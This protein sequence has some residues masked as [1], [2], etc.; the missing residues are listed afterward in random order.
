MYEN[1]KK[2]EERE[3]SF[4]DDWELTQQDLQDI[5]Y[6][7]YVL[8]NYNNYTSDDYNE[9]LLDAFRLATI[10]NRE[11]GLKLFEMISENSLNFKDYE[12]LEQKFNEC[13]RTTTYKTNILGYYINKVKEIYGPD[14]KFRFNEILKK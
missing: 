2:P 3:Y 12:D 5:V 6:C 4:E 8:V 11:V 13:R 1:I 9:W 10:P 14:W 7:V